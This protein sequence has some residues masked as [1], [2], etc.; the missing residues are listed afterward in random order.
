MCIQGLVHFS[1]LPPPPPLPPT[2]PPPSPPPGLELLILL[3]AF[4]CW[5]PSSTGDGGHLIF[6]KAEC[7]FSQFTQAV[8]HCWP[9]GPSASPSDGIMVPL[10][11]AQTHLVVSSLLAL[12]PASQVCLPPSFLPAA[13][14][15]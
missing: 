4:Q 9:R 14:S 6:V 11:P 7:M 13:C 5:D 3:S 10:L 1:P 12:R 8:S 15:K 2:P